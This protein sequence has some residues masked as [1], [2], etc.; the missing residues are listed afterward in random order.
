MS[1][2]GKRTEVSLGGLD[3]LP[4]ICGGSYDNQIH[5]IAKDQSKLLGHLSVKRTYAASVSLSNN[6]IWVTALEA[7]ISH[8][9]SSRPLKLSQ[10]MARPPKAQICLWLFLVIPLWHSTVVPSS[11]LEEQET[12]QEPISMRR[13]RVGGQDPTSRTEDGIILLEC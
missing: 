1:P 4:V 10:K 12:S 7:M 8:T 9:R 13:R 3:G 11:S 6:T 2:L 5:S